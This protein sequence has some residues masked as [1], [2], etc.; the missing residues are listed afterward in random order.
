MVFSRALILAALPLLA[1]A[2][3]IQGRGG[4]PSS[5]ASCCSTV[6]QSTDPAILSALGPLAV[7]VN[8]LN[9]LVGLNCSPITV[10]GAGSSCS[11]TTVTCTDNSHGSAVE[12]GCVPVTL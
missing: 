4:E 9:V 12:I 10:I 6:G 5:G 7:L 3:A 2:T 1:V 8:G 11:G